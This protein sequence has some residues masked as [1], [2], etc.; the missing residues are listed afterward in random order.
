MRRRLCMGLA[1]MLLL[2]GTFRFVSYQ[3]WIF[4]CLAIVIAAWVAD[5]IFRMCDKLLDPPPFVFV[6][7]FTWK[8]QVRF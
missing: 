3:D 7:L 6:I 4:V 5:S 2:V 1:V 8:R